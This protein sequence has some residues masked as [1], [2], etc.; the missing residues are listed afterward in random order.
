MGTESLVKN[1][2]TTPAIAYPLYSSIFLS[3]PIFGILESSFIISS[4]YSIDPLFLKIPSKFKNYG[5][6]FSVYSR[7]SNGMGRPSPESFFRF[8]KIV[9]DFTKGLSRNPAS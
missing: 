5:R 3:T 7:I 1:F 9:R 2:F 6:D 4:Y 8:K